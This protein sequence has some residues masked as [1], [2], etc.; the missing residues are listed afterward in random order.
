MPCVYRSGTN[1]IPPR[2][3]LC[4][5]V[6]KSGGSSMDPEHL[7]SG[8]ELN[9][10]IRMASNQG[11]RGVG[12]LP[13]R[14][15]TSATQTRRRRNMPAPRIWPE[16]H[17]SETCRQGKGWRCLPASRSADGIG[18]GTGRHLLLTLQGQSNVVCHCLRGHRVDHCIRL[19]SRTGG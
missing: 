13:T 4:V 14:T 6:A 9:P 7:L 2:G 5:D 16:S 10:L 18:P 12:V 17:S 1:A 3:E 15:S 8:L 11:G 19:D